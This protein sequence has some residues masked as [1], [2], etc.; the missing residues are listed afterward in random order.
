MEFSN[1]RLSHTEAVKSEFL[2]FFW[3]GRCDWMRVFNYFN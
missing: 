2:P 1:F 3:L